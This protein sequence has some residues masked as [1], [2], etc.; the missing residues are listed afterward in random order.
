[1][2]KPMLRTH[3]PRKSTRM[4]ILQTVITA[5]STRINQTPSITPIVTPVQTYTP[6]NRLAEDAIYVERKSISL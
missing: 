5:S 4:L 3:K 2:L 6:I 1:M